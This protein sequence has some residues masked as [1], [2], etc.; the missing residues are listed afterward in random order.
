MPSVF[1]SY[2][3]KD[4]YFVK[5]LVSLLEYHRISVWWDTKAIVPGYDF[6]LQIDQG[7][8]DTDC[9]IA[10]ISKNAID[11]E[12]MMK[13]VIFFKERKPERKLIPILFDDTRPETILEDLRKYQSIDFQPCFL[14]GFE[15][16]L[17]C[18]G[19]QFLPIT[20]RR[21]TGERRKS[22]LADRMRH[23]FWKFY[24]QSKGITEADAVENDS[25]RSEIFLLSGS[26]AKNMEEF[27]F[28][29]KGTNLPCETPAI[30][31]DVSDR[32]LKIIKDHKKIKTQ[33]L[34]ELFAEEVKKN[35][36]V[37]M[38]DRRLEKERA[39][40]AVG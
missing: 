38:I 40:Y 15:Q 26:L 12:W 32:I 28:Y 1:L 16:L 14:T 2:S 29:E 30:F 3:R 37:E 25:Y 9:L 11:S 17:N 18:F 35:Y 27:R 10:V 5:L 31:D 23:G 20:E 8:K 36:H 19:K 6:G 33:H 13:E 34:V 39:Q 22:S 24:Q 4:I 21:Q 7:L